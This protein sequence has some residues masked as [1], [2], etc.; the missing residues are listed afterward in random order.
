MDKAC[1]DKLGQA[2]FNLS[3]IYFNGIPEAG[4]HKDL[5]KVFE[6]SVKG[7]DYLHVNACANAAL[8]LSKGDGV[9]KNPELAQK[10]REKTKELYDQMTKEGLQ[11]EEGLH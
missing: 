8:M 7:C 3:S 1:D 11:F 10:Y 5:R 6:Y 9:E 4:I 2:C